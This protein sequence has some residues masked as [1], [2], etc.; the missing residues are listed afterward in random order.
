MKIKL[1]RDTKKHIPLLRTEYEKLFHLDGKYN[2]KIL[3][4]AFKLAWETRNY[5]IDKFWIRTV[6]FGGFTALIFNAYISCLS[7]NSGP[8]IEN[9]DIYLIFF[10]LVFSAGWFLSVKGSKKWQE[11]WEA[12][13]DMLEDGI[14]GPLYKIICSD[15][16]K[17]RY[18]S[19]SKINLVLVGVVIIGWIIL[20]LDKVVKTVSTGSSWFHILIG[21]VITIIIIIFMRWYCR[22]TEQGIIEKKILKNKKEDFD[23]GK[24][25]YFIDRYE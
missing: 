4:N 22:S 16:K 19:V 14:T 20:L 8:G 25:T 15:V 21:T 12:H 2:D 7:N 24:L 1:S 17:G 5:E 6:F 23:S 3:E 11:N 13:I 10:G 9:L 18:Y